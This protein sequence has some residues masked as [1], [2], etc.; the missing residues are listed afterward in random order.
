M[1][2]NDSDV[3]LDALTVTGID[4]VTG[5]AASLNAGDVTFDPTANLCGAGAGGYDYT[6]D[7]GNGGT[8][9][10]HVTIDITCV[11]DNPLAGA[12]G[13]VGT[14]DTDVVAR[15]GDLLANDSDVDGD[16]LTVD[17]GLERRP[18]ARV[19]LTDGV[20]T[21]TP[22]AEPVR[23]RRRRL[24][25]HGRRRQRRHATSRT[26]RSTSPASTTPRSRPTTP[27]R[28]PRTRTSSS[29]GGDLTGNDSDIEGDTLTV[30]GVSNA[31]GGSAD[32]RRAAT[33]TFTPDDELCGNGAAGF[34]YT[35]DDGN[36]GTDTGHVTIDLTCVNDDPVGGQRHRH[37]RRGLGR[38]RRHRGHPRQRHRRR[39]RHRPVSDVSNATGGV[40][41][42][43][44]GRRHLHAR[45]R[46]LRQ[47]LRQLRLRDQRRQRRHG[48]RPRRR[49][50]S[51]ASTTRRSPTDDANDGHRGHGRR[52][53]R[54]RP[55]GQRHRH[56]R[57]RRPHGQRPSPTWSAAPPP[58]TTATS[59]SHPTANL[60]GNGAAS[61]DYTVNDGNGGTDTGHVMI[62]LDCVND[63]PVGVDDTGMVDAELGGRG[64][65]RPRQRHRRRGRHAH[66]R[67]RRHGHGLERPVARHRL[68]AREQGPV[69]AGPER[70][71]ARP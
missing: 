54:R 56:R 64:L 29:P 45:R 71:T 31:T 55:D 13:F 61:F 43:D 23:Q 4:N 17:R 32:R 50:T 66:A 21:F 46:R 10:G 3:E 42:P 30:T 8:D 1:V 51:P 52:A 18:A 25:L 36:G 68:D 7:D 34:D 47:R 58:S 19:D 60:C 28:A 49:S 40:G 59:P 5:G 20:V 27:P 6:V 38:Q 37:R 53:H 11:N 41:R 26:S 24:R 14:E 70:S 44:R 2:G 22:D 67:V 48:Q 65:R 12:D 35:V 39:R 57:R 9:T 69:H 15:R 16:A 33:S 62:D 63:A